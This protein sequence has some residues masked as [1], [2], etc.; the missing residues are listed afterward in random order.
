VSLSAQNHAPSLALSRWPVLI[1]PAL[2][3]F[4]IAISG[5]YWDDAWH[6]VEG[7]DSF[8]SP[9]HIA[10]YAGITLAGGAL[11]GWALLALRDS[12]WRR[13]V[14]HP[15]LVLA[16]AGVGITL[17]GAPI[18]N[19]WHEA[20]GRD[21]VLWSPPHMLGVAGTLAIASALLLEL[22]TRPPA[23]FAGATTALAGAGVVA[24]AAVAVLEY[25]TG[26]PQFDP[27][28]YLPVL[29]TGAVLALSLVRQ[30]QPHPWAASWAAAAYTAVM[31][32]VA[33]ILAAAGLPAPLVPLLLI[34]AIVFDLAAPRLSQPMVAVA[35]TVS[36]FAAY[37]PYLNLVLSD[38]FLEAAD[39]AA[40]LPL[41]GL[42]V[43]L[44][45]WAAS[46][47]IHRPPRLA[48]AAAAILLSSSI[49]A[50]LALAPRAEAHDPGQGDEVTQA[51]VR[52]SAT[53]GKAR[54]SV[55]LAGT[56]HCADMTAE[57]L[58]ARRAAEEVTATLRELGPCEFGGTIGLPSRGRWFVYAELD[59]D[60][61]PL[62]TWLSIES[63]A[64]G[65]AFDAD[66]S[67]YAPP[68]TGD[69]PAKLVA[70][71]IIYSVL[72]AAIIGI[73]FIYRRTLGRGV[74]ELG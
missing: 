43:F 46:G 53:D 32:L 41:A 26:V 30:A 12:G 31:V 71:V 29:A 64:E 36:L 1:I 24:V 48:A 61:E 21:A 57:R 11:A 33:L 56:S 13:T 50:T 4:L 14:G 47:R 27:V 60:G 28:F 17:G 39:V 67:V 70:G 2:T 74:P 7:R 68:A 63:D 22:G 62:E 5:T 37:V 6:T 65:A 3:G 25:E 73:P 19:A 20:F 38:V 44:A 72:L 23:R 9:P 8:L 35:F 51:A 54:L 66:R 34:P 52:L 58:V 10:L 42:G 55:D 69:S 49:A 59:H 16:I 45:L 40:G 15:P 18:D